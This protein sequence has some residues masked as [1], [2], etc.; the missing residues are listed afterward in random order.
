MRPQPRIRVMGRQA[1]PG[2]TL[3]ELL[4]VAVIIVLLTVAALPVI[5]TLRQRNISSAALILQAE[6]ARARETAVTARAPRGIRLI[7]SDNPRLRFVPSGTPGSKQSTPAYDR[8]VAIEPAP[9][10]SEGLV[11]AKP[12]FDP[13]TGRFPGDTSTDP[14]ADYLRVQ[15]CLVNYRSGVALP[16]PRTNWFWNIRQGDKFRFN[17]TGHVYTI[18][19]PMGDPS[20]PIPNPERYVHAGPN[21]QGPEFL[22]LVNGVDD[23]SN[24][25]IDDSFDGID[26]D[27]N[28]AYVDPYPGA[29]GVWYDPPLL[30]NTPLTPAQYILAELED[31]KFIGLPLINPASANGLDD[32]GNGIVDDPSETDF[33]QKPYTIQRRPIPSPGARVM[34]LPSGIVVD[35]TSWNYHPERAPFG[36]AGERSRLPIDPL[37]GFVDVMLTPGGQV[38]QAE[39]TTQPG[40]PRAFPF[41]HFWL[42]EADDV[43]SALWGF[44]APTP[45]DPDPNPN[46][47]PNASA[48]NYLLPIPRDANTQ[49]GEAVL[50]GERRLVTINTRTGQVSTNTI[51]DFD[52]TFI[53][54]PFL[55]AQ[56]GVKETP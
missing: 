36:S 37:S 2:F 23:N 12:H 1:R 54:A 19:G 49:A 10:Y 39:A 48:R 11:T 15:E 40:P 35:M 17:D 34:N 46:P 41:Y 14:R 30:T 42:T 32:D 21:Y 8:I 9:D 16:N 22:Y 31:E 45:A 4:V 53:G 29:N 25:Y 6:L 38:V 3:M 5:Q 51:E 50:E 7:P 56:Q 18:V 13:N 26:D 43:S 55:R 28:P 27:A 20:N 47:N 24:G 52:P 44:P 33:T